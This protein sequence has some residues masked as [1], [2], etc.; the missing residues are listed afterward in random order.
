MKRQN[1]YL[2]LLSTCCLASC[3]LEK[4]LTY[5]E[6]CPDAVYYSKSD[7]TKIGEFANP[8]DAFYRAYSITHHCPEAFPVCAQ[9]ASGAFCHEP[10]RDEE[11]FCEDRCILP[12]ENA[13]HCGA[14][15]MCSDTNPDSDDYIGKTCADEEICRKGSCVCARNTDILCDGKC[16]DPYYDMTYCGAKGLCNDA[17]S[18]SVNYSGRQCD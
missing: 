13:A 1:L 18:S 15:G 4:P 10:C 16:I 11:V 17:D 2:I 14:R 7:G 3:S 12:L 9:T 6:D 8:D 5:A